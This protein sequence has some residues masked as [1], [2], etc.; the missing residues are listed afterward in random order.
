M[1]ILGLALVCA[2][3][4]KN[5]GRVPVFPVQGQVLLNGKPVP[6]AFV[7]FHPVAD[8]PHTELRPRAHAEDDGTFSLSTYDN[9]DG[10]P[11]GDY[12]V[13]V[14]AYRAQT[15]NDNGSSTNLL[16]AAYANP[17][18]SKLTARVTA[19]ENEPAVLQLNVKNR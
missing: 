6:H 1:A 10:A 12:L 8:S 9:S 5:N 3:C 16:P 19:G 4:A 2:G 15:E 14:Q 17:A 11:A 7:V 18:T 13:T